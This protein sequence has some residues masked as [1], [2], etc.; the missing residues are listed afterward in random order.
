MAIVITFLQSGYLSEN[1]RTDT[2]VASELIVAAEKY[3][4]K[5]LKLICEEYLITST[6]KVNVV[7]HLKLAHLNNVT[8][9]K[10][11][12]LSLIKLYLSDIMDTPNFITLIQEYQELLL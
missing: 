6:T 10:K 12:A 5:D 3:D 7:E 2:K 11:F 4:L 1:V 9:L 8:I